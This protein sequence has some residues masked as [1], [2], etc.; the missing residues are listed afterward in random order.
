MN[1]L[2]YLLAKDPATMAE[3]ETLAE[4]A[5]HKRPR[6]GA[7]ADTLG[8]IL[9]QQRS[10]ERASRLLE[11]AASALPT[12]PQVHYHLGVVYAEL[13]KRAE[14]RQAL[15]QALKGPRFVERSDAQKLLDSLR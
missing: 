2:A 14:A 13:G 12:Q 10:L 5:Y 15:E 7:I 1:N 8:W 11:Q 3:A 6:S 9:F 4:R